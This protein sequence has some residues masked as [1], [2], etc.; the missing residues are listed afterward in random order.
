MG[1]YKLSSGA[2]G[3]GIPAANSPYVRSEI[4]RARPIMVGQKYYS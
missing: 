2:G 3:D 4:A 1:G